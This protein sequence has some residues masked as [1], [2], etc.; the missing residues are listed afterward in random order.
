MFQSR[1]DWTDLRT[2]LE[3]ATAAI[4]PSLM[5]LELELRHSSNSTNPTKFQ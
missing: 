5:G 3:A 1:V 2:A 4:R